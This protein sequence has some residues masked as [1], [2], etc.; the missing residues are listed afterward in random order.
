MSWSRT[1][2]DLASGRGKTLER[3]YEVCTSLTTTVAHMARPIG[4]TSGCVPTFLPCVN[5]LVSAPA[6]SRCCHTSTSQERSRSQSTTTD[7]PSNLTA[8]PRRRGSGRVVS[9]A[10]TSR[11]SA[12]PSPAL[13]FALSALAASAASPSPFTT[14]TSSTISK[15]RPKRKF[16]CARSLT[17]LAQSSLT[18]F[19]QSLSLSRAPLVA[20]GPQLSANLLKVARAARHRARTAVTVVLLEALLVHRPRAAHKL[21]SSGAS[22][23]TMVGVADAAL[24]R[25]GA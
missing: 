7:S 1:L 19:T 5:S 21:R 6:M 10:S 9:P 25:A 17:C 24:P 14:R 20:I 23:D 15:T 4:N 2:V 3:S 16:P 11:S 22:A 12:V 13:Q 8:P 18:G